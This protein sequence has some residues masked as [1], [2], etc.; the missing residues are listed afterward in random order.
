MKLSSKLVTLLFGLVVSSGASANIIEL[1]ISDNLVKYENQFFTGT[2]EVTADG[3]VVQDGNN[4]VAL[5]GPYEITADSVLN[6]AFSSTV[7]GE[8]HGIGFDNNTSYT[9]LDAASQNRFFQFGGTQFFGIQDFNTYTAADLDSVVEFTINLGD[10]FTGTFNNIIFI[11][12][13]DGKWDAT[14]TYFQ[15][16]QVSGV[17]AVNTAS[18]L[19]LFLIMIASLLVRR[20]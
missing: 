5:E 7:L 17:N 11:N 15:P 10:Y 14:S 13:R 12:D 3:K 18:T 2:A 16:L 8:I 1:N 20:R 6:I 19:G 4:W 9:N